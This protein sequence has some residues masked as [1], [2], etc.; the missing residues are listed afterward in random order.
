MDNNG[1]GKYGIEAYFEKELQGRDGVRSAKKD[2]HGR[3][4]ENFD[5][6]NDRTV[7]GSDITLTIDRNIQKYLGDRLERAT[8]EFR[9]NR[10]SAVILNPKTGAII[11]MASAPGYDPNE[12]SRVYDL[13]VVNPDEYEDIGFDFL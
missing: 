9:A 11:A 2:I 12:Y 6:D 3:T 13:E 7:N 10:V 8:K 1:V 5:L 4:I